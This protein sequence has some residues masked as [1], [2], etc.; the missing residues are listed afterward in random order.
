LGPGDE[1]T[2]PLGSWQLLQRFAGPI[3]FRTYNHPIVDWLKQQGISG[4]SCDHFYEQA[5]D[6][7]GVYE[8]IVRYLLAEVRQSAQLAYCVPGH[9]L[10]AETTVSRLLQCCKAEGIGVRILPAM[11]FLD[12]IYA[13]LQIDPTRGG[14]QILDALELDQ[15]RINP[16][17]GLLLLQVYNRLVASETKLTLMDYYPDEHLV[18]VIR[19]AGLT[20]AQRADIPLYELDRL[21]WIDHLTSVYLPPCPEGKPGY[22]R[23]ALEPLAEVMAKLRSPEGCPWD[24]E[25]THQTLKPYLI[26]EAYEVLEAIDQQDMEALCEE[27][28]DVL[29]QVVFH[30]QIACE[31]EYFDLNDVIMVI[32]EKMIRR[33]PH[34]FADTRVA[35][36]SEVI[37]NWEQIKAQE[38][39]KQ[40]QSDKS[41]LSGIPQ[42]LPAL[43]QAYKIQAKAAR[44]GFDW[45]NWQGAWDKVQ[46]ELK[47]L[48]Q[49]LHDREKRQEELGDLLFALVNLARFFEIDPEAALKGTCRK[50]RQRF[51][52]IEA[53]VQARG[54]KLEELDLVELDKIWELAKNHENISKKNG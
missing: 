15:T 50:F 34:V 19:G 30:A 3:V 2:F 43:L 44:V 14:L 38:K 41:L 10:V 7:A 23:F 1:R 5:E 52:F 33:H 29:L 48:G 28:G 27:L 26:E 53:T 6:F 24:R 11:S 32:T 22:G 54:Q 49:V 31:H 13:E 16:G 37:R 17:Q 12:A 20:G 8:N 21:P 35:S 25:Q 42:A 40:G 47:E 45:D 4:S 46:E 36:S 51:A 18:T 39:H 9:P